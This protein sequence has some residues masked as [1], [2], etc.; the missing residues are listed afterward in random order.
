MATAPAGFK[1]RREVRGV[2]EDDDSGI[3]ESECGAEEGFPEQHRAACRTIASVFS[4]KSWAEMGANQAA[5]RCEREGRWGVGFADLNRPRPASVN[6]SW[7]VE[8]A[9]RPSQ[10]VP[11]RLTRSRPGRLLPRLRLRIH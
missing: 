1:A 5:A 6:E 4:V 3:V 2:I 9:A 10:A 8:V 11:G 7:V